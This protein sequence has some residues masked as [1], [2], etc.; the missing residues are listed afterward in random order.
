MLL[1]RCVDSPSDFLEITRD[2]MAGNVVK[3]DFICFGFQKTFH[4]QPSFRSTGLSFALCSFGRSFCF[5]KLD[6]QC[7][8]RT[9]VM[10]T[11][12]MAVSACVI[13][14]CSFLCR[15]LQNNNVKWPRWS[16]FEITFANFDAVL[17]ILF[18]IS[19][20]VINKRNEYKLWRDS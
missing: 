13:I 7:K 3:S 17:H 9:T 4:S 18:G 16:V 10:A 2:E 6:I 5:R 20:A 12:T 14:F 15:S 19:L 1:A 11:S 8:Q